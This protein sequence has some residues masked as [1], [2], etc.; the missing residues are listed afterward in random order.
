M[1][2]LDEGG[3]QNTRLRL[4]PPPPELH[5]A[6]EHFWVQRAMPKNV[7]RIVPDVCAYAIFSVDRSSRGLV[8]N[9][10]ITGARSTYFD[11]HAPARVLSIG[12]RLRAGV[13]PELVGHSAYEL[14]DRN[15]A[16]Q[17]VASSAGRRLVEEMAEAALRG[18]VGQ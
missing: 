8:A 14:T 9:G 13:L 17:D 11:L 3:W 15:I 4:I 7:W 10:R 6:V 16:M 12:A 18:A 5:H 1:V 2:W